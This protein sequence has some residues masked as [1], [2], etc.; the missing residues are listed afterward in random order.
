MTDKKYYTYIAAFLAILIPLPGRFVF[1]F[2]VILEL[3]ILIIIGILTDALI[4]LLKITELRTIIILL[5]TIFV[6]VLYRQI[7]II[8]QTE[9]ALILGFSVYLPAISL[10]ASGFLFNS[11][12]K[13]ENALN[14]QILEQENLGKVIV[15]NLIDIAKIS[16]FGL[17]F[18]LFR[19][20]AGYGTFTFFGSQHKIFEK[21]II[22]SNSALVFK[23]FGSI[24][25]ALILAAATIALYII[26][27]DKAAK[28]QKA[29]ALK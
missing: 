15:K 27:K 20:I 21:V 2:T 29:E 4:K 23:F 8:F 1:G 22:S 25:G 5:V 24:P 12:E 17:I 16:V 18:T 10:F 28:I 11:K 13:N 3:A 19:D 14:N 9:V 7:L 6:S 26:I